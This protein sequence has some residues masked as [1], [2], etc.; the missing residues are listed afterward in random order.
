MKYLITIIV[1]VLIPLYCIAQ[2][3]QSNKS[4]T[5]TTNKGKS[6]R[7]E[8]DVYGDIGRFLNRYPIEK[9]QVQ[10]DGQQVSQAGITQLITLLRGCSWKAE[11][12]G[13][14]GSYA[15]PYATI[16]IKVKG[17]RKKLEL[18]VSG[19][20][21]DVSDWS[22][23]GNFILIG[24]GGPIPVD[25]YGNYE[26]YTMY[27][28]LIPK[29][30]EIIFQTIADFK[31]V[32][33]VDT[34]TVFA[35]RIDY[36]IGGLVESIPMSN[37]DNAEFLRL[38]NHMIYSTKHLGGSLAY[39][40]P[41]GV[42]YIFAYGQNVLQQISDYAQQSTHEFTD[43]IFSEADAKAMT[44]LKNKY[45][46]LLDSLEYPDGGF[47]TTLPNGGRIEGCYLHG[48][49]E[50][51]WVAY[52]QDDTLLEVM[53]YRDGKKNG[54]KITYFPL[55]KYHYKNDK[56]DGRYELYSYNGGKE[57]DGKYENGNEVYRRTFHS[58][59]QLQYVYE[60][61]DG[62]WEMLEAYDD[63]GKKRE[64]K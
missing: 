36:T 50:G 63:Q 47:T 61:I 40:E 24:G 29:I 49:R 56:L 43:N 10:V 21:I 45:I 48:K 35:K 46:A 38:Y 23:G 16:G 27:A 17:V 22:P 18:L 32:E 2:N 5:M 30:N 20:G 7:K 6:M 14:C 64:L 62:N 53:T 12:F 54:L 37:E 25:V 57:Q 34:L 52:S 51:I 19:N 13:S 41:S 4:E 3:E 26:Q 1:T 59:G 31:N 42:E 58:N 33:I 28:E 11:D 44:K 9:Y 39:E 8:R 55:S 60:C 15:E